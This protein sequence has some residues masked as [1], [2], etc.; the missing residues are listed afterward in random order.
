VKAFCVPPRCSVAV[1]NIFYGSEGYLVVNGYDKYGSFLGRDKKPGPSRKEGGDH[2]L[3]FIQAV[4]AHDKSILN[5]PVE[6]AHLSSA[7]AHLGNIAYRIGR[8]LKFDPIN[9]KFINDDEA[10]TLL[11]RPP[12]KPFAVPEKV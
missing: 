10:N 11:T 2:Y 8:T 3:N 6:T 1:G 5:A 7:L 12:R 4:R 9:E